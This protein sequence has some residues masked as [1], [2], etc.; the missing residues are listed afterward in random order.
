MENIK[1]EDNKHV[2]IHVDDSKINS[3]TKLGN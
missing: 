3:S 1:M 2:T